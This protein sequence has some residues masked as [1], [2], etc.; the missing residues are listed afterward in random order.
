MVVKIF[1]LL[2]YQNFQVQQTSNVCSAITVCTFLRRIAELAI[3]FTGIA[4]E[5][6]VFRLIDDL[7]RILS[8]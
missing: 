5:Q 3:A 2:V 8:N 1:D 7:H 6:S 4:Q